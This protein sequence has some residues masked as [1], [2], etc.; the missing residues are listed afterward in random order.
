MSRGR[1]QPSMQPARHIRNLALIG[2]MATGKS[3]VGRA[4]AHALDFQFVDTDALI[5]SRL[6]RKIS[7]VFSQVGEAWFREFERRLVLEMKGWDRVVIATGGGL[8]AQ[9]ANLAALQEHALVVCLW[10]SPEIIWSRARRHMHRPLLQTPDPQGRIRQL[11]A[12]RAPVYRQADV[13]VNT[14]RRPL[15]RVVQQVLYHFHLARSQR[16]PA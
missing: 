14:E 4:A 6:D 2:F 10:A 13:L 12:E 5:E 7:E 3:S 9:L 15:R 8:G 16:P 11:L 1:S